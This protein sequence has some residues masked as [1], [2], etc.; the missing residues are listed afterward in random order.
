M[1]KNKYSL[2]LVS[3]VFEPVSKA[4]IFSKLDHR[5]T[6]HLPRIQLGDEWKTTFKT[7]I[8]HYKYLVM[9]FGLSNAPAIFQNLVNNIL[10]DFLKKFIF[11]YPDEIIIFSK[12]LEEQKTQVRV[13]PAK[14]QDIKNWPTPYSRKT[15]TML[16]L[17]CQLLPTFHSELQ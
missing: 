2:R 5:N 4:S 12:T 6:Y 16:P 13:H 1:V 3:L 7:H 15:A 11:I 14:T 8:G 10:R 9:P 17:L